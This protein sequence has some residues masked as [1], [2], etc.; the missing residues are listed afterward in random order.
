MN[1]NT[2][3]K[4]WTLILAIIWVVNCLLVIGI[5]ITNTWIPKLNAAAKPYANVRADA[6]NGTVMPLSYI[7]D[8]KKS[9]LQNKSLNF[10][11]I[12]TKDLVP[13]PKYNPSTLANPNNWFERYTY[14]VVYMGSYTLNYK[15]NDGSHL[16][17]D[18]RSP[19]GTPVLAIANG[20][21]VRTVEADATGNKFV[22][23]RHENV[24]YN[25]KNVDL[26]SAYLHLS[27]IVAKE[28]TKIRKGEMLGRV[29]MT[30]IT[31]TPHLHLQIDTENAPFFP[32]W[33][34]TGT[35]ARN[36]GLSFLQAV[37]AGLG[38]DRARQFTINPLEFVQYYLSGDVEKKFVETT[39]KI[40][41][42]VKRLD[43][44]VNFIKPEVESAPEIKT[45]D[46]LVSFTEDPKKSVIVASAT[47]VN[48]NLCKNLSN[49]SPNSDF[50]NVLQKIS[51]K[52]CI[53]DGVSPLSPDKK[54]TRA[55]ALSVLL[56]YY[57]EAPEDGLS[58]F[59]DISLG[60]RITQANALKA[61]NKGIF[62]GENFRPYDTLT[63]AE[64]LEILARFG[65]LKIAPPDYQ[66]YSDIEK[67]SMYYNLQ[68][69]AYT[70]GAKNITLLP[71]REITQYEVAKFLSYLP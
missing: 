65:K 10:R 58:P 16:A 23:V 36:A 18:I 59:S 1:T 45:L 8:W 42:P 13:L 22:V 12:P 62:T 61:F 4:S 55:E 26:Y 64:F 44:I 9:E 6:F 53:F 30:G 39:P 51:Q 20:V 32:Y 47:F 27:E 33:P 2:N 56:K 68:N 63:R 24:P 52:S 69:F 46:E 25:G 35:E 66:G 14:P 49:I 43:E 54:I 17:V 48:P 15:E 3:K 29:G 21:V 19:I 11:D 34:Y 57:N 7:P 50:S 38:A 5:V 71:N 60:D 70:I 67:N 31:T 37:T 40:T 28:G 41:T